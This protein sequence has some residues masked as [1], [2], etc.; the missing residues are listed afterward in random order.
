MSMLRDQIQALTTQSLPATS[1][2]PNLFPTRL[3]RLDQRTSKSPQR[4][5]PLEPMRQPKQR[6][7]IHTAQLI[8][9]T[10]I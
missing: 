9:S 5:E 1:H 3:T 10:K 8:F 6:R 2:F 4:G 7:H